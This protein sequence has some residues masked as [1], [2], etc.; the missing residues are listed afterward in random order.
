MIHIYLP[1]P[2]NWPPTCADMFKYSFF[3]EN[4]HLKPLKLVSK[5]MTNNITEV[6]WIMA[7]CLTIDNVTKLSIFNVAI[8]TLLGNTF[9][10]S[11]ASLK[12]T[13]KVESQQI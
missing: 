13:E 2:T 5:G 7:M 4:L 9:S 10:T 12:T 1:V 11:L 8:S 6:V 3:H